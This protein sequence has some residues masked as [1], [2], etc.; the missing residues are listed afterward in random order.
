M[1]LSPTE[2]QQPPIFVSRLFDET[3]RLLVDAQDYFEAYAGPD[4]HYATPVERLVYSAEM[5][6]ITLRL[7]SIMA[8]LMAR[9]AEYAGEISREEAVSQFRLT[10]NE[11]C[12]KELPEMHFV[13]PSYVCELLERSLDL[14]RRTARLDEMIAE[15]TA[16]PH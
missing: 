10:F 1:E 12:L 14:Y 4:Q 16:K 9:R 8:W 11:I 15:S 3:M 2:K 6:R 13:L 5:S 7:S